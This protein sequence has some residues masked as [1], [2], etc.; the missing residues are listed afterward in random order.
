MKQSL[1][2]RLPEIGEMQDFKSFIAASANSGG[3]KFIAHCNHRGQLPHLKTLYAPGTD[4]LVLIGPEGD[5]TMDEVKLALDNGFR[6]ISLGA[7][8]LRTETAALYACMA[9]NLLND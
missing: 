6:E 1:K 2:A 9:I 3:Q 7:S 5:F 8:R 4:A